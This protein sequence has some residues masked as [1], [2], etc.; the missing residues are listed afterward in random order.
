MASS[1]DGALELWVDA[2]YLGGTRTAN[3]QS[4]GVVPSSIYG[5]ALGRNMNQGP[6]LVQSAWWGRIRVW[7]SNPGF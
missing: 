5:L 1:A 3:V 6:G 7:N 4:G 2:S